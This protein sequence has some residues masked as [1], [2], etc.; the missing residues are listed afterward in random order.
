VAV[1]GIGSSP[2]SADASATTPTT[3]PTNLY[4]VSQNGAVELSWGASPG[5]GNTPV[6]D[7]Y[8]GAAAGGEGGT[9]VASTTATSYTMSGLTNGTAYFFI[10]IAN[11]AAGSTPAS[12][13]IGVAPSAGGGGTATQNGTVVFW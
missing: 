7:I 3:A 10:V 2:Q 9:Y 8:E 6:Y 5:A 12:N 4:G 1:N 13:E 11:N